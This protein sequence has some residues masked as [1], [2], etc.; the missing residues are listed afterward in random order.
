[1]SSTNEA[2]NPNLLKERYLNGDID[3]RA[4]LG[5][6]S[7][8]GMAAGVIGL[9]IEAF[10]Q[11]GGVKEIRFENW[12]G[13]ATEAMRKT[14]VVAFEKATSIKVI[15]GT[16]GREEEMLAKA[17]LGRPGEYNIT[18]S[19]GIAWYKRWTDAGLGSVLNEAM[20]PNLR[21]VI[22]ALISPF[23]KVTPAG[24]SAVPF[25][26]GNTGIIFNKKFISLERAKAEREK[27]LLAPEFKGKISSFNDFQTRMWVAALQ[28]GQDPN[29]M[30]DLDAVWNKIRENRSL[31]K[32]YWDSGT[33]SVALLAAGEVY[34][35]DI[36]SGRASSLI[37]E[38]P[39]FG[40]VEFSTGYFWPTDLLVI[41]GAPMAAC[42][43]FLNFVLD[44]DVQIVIAEAQFYPPAL[45]P[46]KV[47]MSE[48]I[49]QLPNFDPSGT[50]A[51]WNYTDPDYWTK[52]EKDWKPMFSR[53]AKGF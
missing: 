6:V 50:F 25:S 10:A 28:T 8:A 36:W 33:E 1:M 31:L 45:D 52:Y 40:Y 12:G 32:K 34:V 7:A 21:N 29:N 39:D 38:N 20:I 2:H 30:K 43:Q 42:E 41:K 44:P 26:Y 5:L 4:F 49:K 22:P 9:P 13:L 35:S 16:F 3:R 19:A 46:T 27:L 47:K 48:K 24:L 18:S 17:K 23:R 11:S 51:N 53:I 15:E 37:A 14:A